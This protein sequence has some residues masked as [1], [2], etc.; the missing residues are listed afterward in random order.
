LI[1]IPALRVT[2]KP[3]LGDHPFVKLECGR[4]KQVVTQWRIAYWIRY[5]IKAALNQ[6]CKRQS[7]DTVV[8][9]CRYQLSAK[10]PIIG[11]CYFSGAKL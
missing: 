8:I 11:A 4:S 7:A 10:W 1:V 2:V 5:I 9:I 6:L 3:A